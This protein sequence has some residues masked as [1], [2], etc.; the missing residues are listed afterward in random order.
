VSTTL[1]VAVVVLVSQIGG[2]GRVGAN[3]NT[4]STTNWLCVPVCGI[5]DDYYY[6]SSTFKLPVRVCPVLVRFAVMGHQGAGI[7]H[8]Q[9]RS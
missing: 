8:R 3:L 1:P 5:C 6:N 9:R 7:W 4:S 2:P